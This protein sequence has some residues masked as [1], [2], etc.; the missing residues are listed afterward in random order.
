VKCVVCVGGV[1]AGWGVGDLEEADGAHELGDKGVLRPRVAGQRRRAV[2][3]EAV[4]RA[5][6][7]GGGVILQPP[8]TTILYGESPLRQ[9]GRRWSGLC[10]R[11]RLP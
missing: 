6:G 11:R 3:A 7:A 8:C 1:G 2:H 5:L 10:Y 9:A 4:A